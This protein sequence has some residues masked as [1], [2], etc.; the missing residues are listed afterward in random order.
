MKRIN[1]GLKLAL[2]HIKDKNYLHFTSD[3]ANF[4]FST[5]EETKLKSLAESNK[6]EII[7]SILLYIKNGDEDIDAEQDPSEDGEYVL[8]MLEGLNKIGIYW[9]E[10][11]IISKSF[12]KTK[13]R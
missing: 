12:K 7:K 3:I 6:H 13:K 8:F 9:D 11:E 4:D 5:L 10:L 1:Y 2:E